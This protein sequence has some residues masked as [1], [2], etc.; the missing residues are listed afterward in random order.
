MIELTV[1]VCI[2][3]LAVS[4]LAALVRIARGPLV[5]D[6]L[7]AFDLLTVCGVGMMALLSVL[8]RTEHYLELVLVFSL[9][10]FLSTVA[11]TLYLNKTLP[12][13]R[14][15]EEPSPREDEE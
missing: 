3:L 5:I 14:Q 13:P 2:G 11:F 7:L 1:H 6:R 10:G 8:W 9:L 4:V 12:E 15:E